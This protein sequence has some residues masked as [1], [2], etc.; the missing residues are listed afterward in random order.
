MVLPGLK[1]TGGF[2]LPWDWA[3]FPPIEIHYGAWLSVI[4]HHFHHTSTASRRSPLAP[5]RLAA[6]L[7]MDLAR[8]TFKT[9]KRGALVDER[10]D[11]ACEGIAD[12]A[13]L[14]QPK[15][16]QISAQI[17]IF[18][19]KN[20]WRGQRTQCR[21]QTDVWKDSVRR[22]ASPGN[23]LVSCWPRASCIWSLRISSNIQTPF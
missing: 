11:A 21:P 18:R 19:R 12:L 6:L 2:A 10:R 3:S 16:S 5:L 13:Q 8:R 15:P 23:T 9:A 22:S 20:N 4:C 1:S 14:K 7:K 17:A